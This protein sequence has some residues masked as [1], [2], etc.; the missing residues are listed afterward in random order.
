MFVDIVDALRW[1]NREID[2]FGGDPNKVVMAGHSSGAVAA[3][4][5]N[6][7]FTT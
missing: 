2:V 6:F 1:T 4:F 5:V 3:A 7:P